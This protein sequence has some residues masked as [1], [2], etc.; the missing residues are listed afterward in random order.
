MR[1][2]LILTYSLFITISTFFPITVTSTPTEGDCTPKGRRI[3][4]ASTGACGF[5]NNN[6][7]L[8][9]ATWAVTWPDGIYDELKLRGSGACSWHT[10]CN[11]L[12]S[13]NSIYCWPDFYPPTVTSEGN[14]SILVVNQ[15]VEEVR[16][17]RCGLSIFVEVIKTC[18]TRGQ[19]IFQTNHT[20]SSFGGSGDGE[21]EC[22]G[23]GNS[24]SDSS[25]CCNGNCAGGECAPTFDPNNGG[26]GTPV[27]IDVSGNGFDLT[28]AAGGV[29]FD[30][31]TNSVS[32]R[33]SWTTAATDDAWLVLDRNGNGVINNGSELFGNF[34]PQ[35]EPPAGQA[36]NGF[37][38]LAEYDKPANGGNGDRVIDRNDAVFV[39]L[40][41]WQD[42]NH[43]GISESSELHM[44]SAL[45]VDSISVDFKESKRTDQYG[46]QFRYRAMVKDSKGAELGRWAWDVILQP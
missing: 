43:N 45:N 4:E 40:R 29:N 30:L 16:T 39:S 27:L 22:L 35:P 9:E 28:D 1:Y 2:R 23:V 10:S 18:A 6:T 31:N 21:G 46:N 37:F 5:G 32:E 7:L 15:D 36:R 26:G 17:T 33:I 3:Q 13:I 11:D 8:K 34:T 38:A 20:C 41:L 19:T 14:F 12:G 42:T 24:C 25:E 44:L